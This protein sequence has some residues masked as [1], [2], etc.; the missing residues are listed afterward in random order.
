[1]CDPLIHCLDEGEER[2]RWRAREPPGSVAVAP[3]ERRILIWRMR[4]FQGRAMSR[5]SRRWCATKG[6]KDGRPELLRYVKKK[7]LAREKKR[8][9]EEKKGKYANVHR[10]EMSVCRSE[11]KRREERELVFSV[12]ETD[13]S[14]GEE[15]QRDSW[16][17]CFEFCGDRCTMW[18]VLSFP[19][20][21]SKTMETKGAL[22]E[23]E[24]KAW[25]RFFF[26]SLFFF[27]SSLHLRKQ[28]ITFPF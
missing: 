19:S 27:W 16:K 13:W 10:R 11:R 12:V 1:M 26:P 28:V 23:R 25:S 7:K 17:S 3:A 5:N 2:W 4:K 15:I 21:G 8:E 20:S 22:F 9:K 6:V 14:N 18:K 24:T